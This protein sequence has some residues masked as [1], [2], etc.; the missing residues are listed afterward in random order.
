MKRGSRP[1]FDEAVSVE[2]PVIA[3]LPDVGQI[4]IVK[5]I[6]ERMP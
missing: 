5:V 6:R 2:T 4:D 1:L 3:H